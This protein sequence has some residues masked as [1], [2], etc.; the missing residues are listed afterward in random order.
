MLSAM[1]R[2]QIPLRH[3]F[4]TPPTPCPYLPDRLER[5]VVTLLSGE[6]AD[7]LHEA[8]SSAGFRRSQDLAY[9]PACDGCNACVPV[10][11]PIADFVPAR[12]HRRIAKRNAAVRGLTQAPVAAR[13]HFALFRSY[14]TS[15]HPGG[16]MA[17]M[18]FADYRA[19]IE[20]TPVDTS[21]VDFR[22]PDGSL[23]A[24]CLTDRM[25]DG[26]SLVYS[27]F[28][29]EEADRSPGIY[30]ILWHVDRARALGLDYVYLGYWIEQ[31]PKMAYKS[32]F[33]PIEALRRDGW[34]RLGEQV[35]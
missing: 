32:Q 17:D 19:M 27:F 11:I 21:L 1:Q 7:Q 5:K 20:D 6:N 30:I 13:E 8:L 35:D 4:A 10:R 16:G 26:L 22:E 28:D 9:R 15:R 25:A 14:L 18:G 33:E 24:V 29:P 31:S 23:Y 3:F 2:V 12:S 34:R